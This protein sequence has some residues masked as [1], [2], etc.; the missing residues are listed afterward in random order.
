MKLEQA[1]VVLRPRRSW[2]AIDLG[3]H[4]ARCWF[5]P[6][7]L[8]WMATA[9]PLFLLLHL[10]LPGS[11]GIAVLFFWWLKPLYEP[12]MTD[13]LGRALFNEQTPLY[14]QLRRLPPVLRKGFPGN[15]T[16]RRLSP[17]RSFYLCIQQLEGLRGTDFSNRMKLL[18]GTDP[19]SGWLT[20]LMF[21]IESILYLGV[22]GLLFMLL[23]ETI[24]LDF[25]LFDSITNS[26]A[27][28]WVNS[29]LYMLAASII[30][31]F[32]VAAGFSLYINARTDLEAWDIEIGFRHIAR[33][34]ANEQRARMLPGSGS[35]AIVLLLFV[36]LSFIGPG[37]ADAMDRQEARESIAEV[38]AHKD[39]GEKVVQKEWRAKEATADTPEDESPVDF[40]P[41]DLDWLAFLLR[42]FAYVVL[43]VFAGW[44]AFRIASSIT[45]FRLPGKRAQSGEAPGHRLLQPDDGIDDGIPD[46]PVDAAIQLCE[47]GQ[48][49]KAMSLLYR[50]TILH[51]IRQQNIDIPE[52]ATEGECLRLVRKR[53]PE[54][55]SRYFASLTRRWQ[56]LAYAG[57]PLHAE[58]IVELCHQWQAVYSGEKNAP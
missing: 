42:L 16:W 41:G 11:F 13:W 18:Q 9:G 38:L 54:Q 17:S 33:E 37:T 1:A 2:E 8:M 58:Q 12:L 29:A 32:Y 56:E 34:T 53:R 46:N 40:S 26:T 20:V 14:R 36:T 43:G 30:A 31:P 45:V 51:Y 19:N 55:E 52:S 10:L 27:I 22:I 48:L 57:S 3:F 24:E 5:V 28:A 7:W 15:I 23:P 47:E 6:L 4:M 39:F 44:L 35:A 49:R 25:S 50:S 21:Q